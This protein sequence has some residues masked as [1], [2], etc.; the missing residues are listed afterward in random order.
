MDRTDRHYRAFMRSL[1]RHTLLYT[2][3]V[4][5]KA[6]LHGDRQLLLGYSPIEHPLALQLGGDDPSELAE[7]ARIAE[8]MGYLEV[9]VNIGCPSE[10][11]QQGSFGACLMREPDTV[12]RCVQAMREATEL[13]ITVKHRI[14][15]DDLDRYEDMVN[16]VRR[17][18][19]AGCDRFSVHARKAWLKGLSPKQNRTVPPLR[20]AEVYRLKAEH[21]ELHI[22]INGGVRTFEEALEHLK[23]VDAVMIGRA[24]YEQPYRFAE[25]DQRLFGDP[26]PVVTRRQAI[27]AF[28]PYFDQDFGPKHKL[29][30]IT[31]HLLN[32]FAGVPGNKA[33]KR[34][35]MEGGQRGIP[36]PEVVLEALDQAEAVLSRSIEAPI[37]PDIVGADDNSTL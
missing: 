1:T 28:L 6:I 15:V 19:E 12:A 32:L 23:H 4:V 9:N 11:V 18:A 30:H 20:Y 3:M 2:E 7:C 29:H 36:G 16:F 34:A 25:A 21:P 22:E 5:T 33:W 10:R 37:P 35:L 24:A 8:G 26:R 14:G 17:V 27:E 13:P 31:R